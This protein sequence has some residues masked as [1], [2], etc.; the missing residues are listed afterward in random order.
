V[1]AIPF[2]RLVAVTGGL[3][4]HNVEA[5]DD[6]DFF[7][8]TVP[9]RLWLARAFVLGLVLFARR[10][11]LELCP[12]YLL[13]TDALALPERGSY[14]ARELVQMVPLYGRAVYHDL[15]AANTWVAQELPNAYLPLPSADLDDL[16]PLQRWKDAAERLLGG[17]LGDTLERFERTRKI[18]KLTR[19]LP[20]QPADRT[21]FDLDQCKGH[22]DGHGCRVTRRFADQLA[23][24]GV[25]SPTSSSV[26][27]G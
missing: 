15:R 27:C 23:R 11:G 13:S 22:F 17:W 8:A 10:R 26:Q 4:V 21:Q 20:R 1:A 25:Q 2:V 24:Y 7:V 18:R 19:G 9:G 16:G 6:V 5:A 14:A 3:A 12:N